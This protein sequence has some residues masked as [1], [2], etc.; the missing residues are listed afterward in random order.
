MN[1]KSET[2]FAEYCSKRGY[3]ASRIPTPT[4]GKQF[5]DFD[6]I[7]G[8]HRII[9]EVKELTAS[10]DDETTANILQQHLPQVFGDEPGR[11]VRKQ[12]ERAEPQLRRYE[13]QNVPCVVVL[14]DN[15]IVDGFRPFPPGGFM[16]DPMNALWPGNIDFGM[17][18]LQA[19]KLRLHQDGQTESLG[20]V[21]GGKRTL[22]SQHQ[23]N[24]SAVVT[25][26]DYAPDYGLFVVVYH[27]FFAKNPLPKSVFSHPKDKQLEK[28]EHPE[29]CPGKWAIA[30][31][32][33]ND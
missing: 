18:G 29:S 10:P 30:L 2:L 1:T 24:I 14:Y 5:P 15:I 17:F 11:R 27:N 25:L 32:P 12:I 7:I 31:A 8:E 20:D 22:R 19:V 16:V 6:V 3:V 28:P 26:H 33:D 21:R 4:D 9:A 23:D 13:N